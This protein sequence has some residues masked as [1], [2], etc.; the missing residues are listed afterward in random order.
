MADPPS[1]PERDASGPTAGTPRWVKVSGIIALAVVVLLI[2]LLLTG[3]NHGPGRHTSSDG[4]DGPL[5]SMS[6]ATQDR[7]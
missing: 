7:R 3:S 2:I 1:S 5:P 4:L 6:A